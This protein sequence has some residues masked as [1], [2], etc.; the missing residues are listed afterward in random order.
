M[1]GHVAARVPPGAPEVALE[2]AAIRDG[3]IDASFRA[4]VALPE[5]LDAQW[6]LDEPIE[7]LCGPTHPLANSAAVTP[8]ELAG[9]RIRLPGVVPGT[10]WGAYYAEFAAAFDL[11]IDAAGPNFGIE[12]VLDTIAESSE[13]ATLLG[14][15]SRVLWPPGHDLRRVP[16]E[17]P[18][19]VYPHSLVWR[20]GNAHPGL[21]ALR[22]H[23]AKGERAAGGW[24]PSW[25]A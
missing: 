16:I 25:A 10:E 24:R 14:A 20:R 12:V 9:H 1:P 8:A 4:V 17:A 11:W 2:V 23:L 13:V 18:V 7:L 15:G 21:A 22:R 5:D 19:P 3:S 6:V